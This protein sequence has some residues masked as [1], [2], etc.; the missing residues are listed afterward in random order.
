MGR[1]PWR[2]SS[3]D[4]AGLLEQADRAGKRVGGAEDPAV[5]MVA[6]QDP[7]LG[8]LGAAHPRDH[9][10]GRR[11]LPIEFELEMDRGR[12]GADVVGDGQR[13]APRLGCDRAP[14]VAQQRLGVA[15]GDRQ[16]GNARER[17]R[18]VGRQAGGI[19][20]RAL[21]V[22]RR[23]H[24]GRERVAGIGRHVHHAAAL[25]AVRRPVSALRINVAAIV[26]VVPRVGVNDAADGAVLGG[27]F[28]FD[29]APRAAVACDD[30]LALHVDAHLGQTLVVGRDA[31]VDVD[32]L[33]RDVAVD[34][35]G[36]VDGQ[37]A[38]GVGSALVAFHGRLAEPR[39]V[40]FRRDHLE[41]TRA[42]RREQRIE[43]LDRGF[44]TPA[45]E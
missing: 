20:G 35:V 13:A 31:V 36:V 10:V 34:G 18:F 32:Q 29:A 16:N 43:G 12:A 33:A 23:A 42:R 26:A 21:G 11:Q 5:V 3:G 39:G 4:A 17:Q 14:E 44:V 19:V 6:A 40:M 28:G 45:L 38:G 22:Q 24:S 8:P 2:A 15:V 25:G 9:V 27:Y 30:D 1:Q 7:F 37:T 41:Q